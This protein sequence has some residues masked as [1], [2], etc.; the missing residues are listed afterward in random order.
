[1]ENNEALKNEARRLRVPL[2]R[3]G[4][5]FG[6]SEATIQRALRRPLPDERYEEYLRA[7][8]S[9]AREEAKRRDF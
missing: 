4:E 8:H 1:M 2:W 9:L 5:R 7:I 6:V 3:L